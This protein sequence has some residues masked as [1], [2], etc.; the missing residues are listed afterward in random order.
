MTVRAVQSAT[1]L[2]MDDA[3]AHDAG[4]AYGE[5]FPG[6]QSTNGLRTSTCLTRVNAVLNVLSV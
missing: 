5:F 3:R 1:E 2:V 6:A 4:V